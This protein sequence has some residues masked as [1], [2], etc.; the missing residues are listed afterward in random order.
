MY[1]NIV[2]LKAVQDSAR[3]LISFT[4]NIFLALVLVGGKTLIQII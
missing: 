2:D 1:T 3:T 4:G